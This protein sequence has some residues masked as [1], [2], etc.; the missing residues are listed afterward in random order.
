MTSRS[1]VALVEHGSC[2]AGLLAEI[3]WAVDRSYMMQDAFEG[4]NRPMAAIKLSASNFGRYP[5][6]QRPDPPRDPLSGRAG[7][8]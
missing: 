3:L 5:D 4:D 1:L 8:G 6:G 2:F 7:E